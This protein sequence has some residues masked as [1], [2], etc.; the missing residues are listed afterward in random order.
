[1]VRGWLGTNEAMASAYITVA[2]LSAY[3][4]AAPSLA[5]FTPDDQLIAIEAASSEFEAYASSK[6][7]VPLSAVPVVAKLHI[8]RCAGYHLLGSRGFDP[9]GPDQLIQQGYKDALKWFQDVGAGRVP[10]GPVPG[11]PATPGDSGGS[12]FDP[13]VLSNDPRGLDYTDV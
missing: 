13:S 9:Q 11:E 2:E 1:M 3:A 7:T 4:L 5:R 12:V 8:A 6:H 10:L